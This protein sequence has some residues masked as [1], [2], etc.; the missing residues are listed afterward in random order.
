MV[1]IIACDE[2]GHE[3]QELGQRFHDCAASEVLIGGY[4]YAFVQ[5]KT[6]RIALYRRLSLERLAN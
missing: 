3:L 2:A 5:F 1:E 4:L 6:P